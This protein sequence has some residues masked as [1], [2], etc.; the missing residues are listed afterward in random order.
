M[1]PEPPELDQF[2]GDERE[3]VLSLVREAR[4]YRTALGKGGPLLSPVEAEIEQFVGRSGPRSSID[5]MDFI[6]SL[7]DKGYSLPESIMLEKIYVKIEERKK[8][9]RRAVER[10]VEEFMQQAGKLAEPPMGQLLQ[11]L[12][13]AGLAF[14]ADDVRRL[15]QA[16][17]L[18]HA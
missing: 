5:I 16:A 14:D 3:Q 8:E 9:A 6:R 13:D 10:E 7:K 17:L 11:R 18:R 2:S 4:R 12:T 15:A 1:T